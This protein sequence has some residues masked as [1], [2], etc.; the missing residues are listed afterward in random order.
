V[1]PSSS[2][3]FGL[4]LRPR[5]ARP[6]A[7]AALLAALCVG[8]A[9]GADAQQQGLYAVLLRGPQPVRDLLMFPPNPLAAQAGDYGLGEAR[10]SV[11][12]TGETLVLPQAWRARV[13]GELR[14]LEVTGQ[15]PYSLCFADPEGAFTLFFSFPD[16]LEE[17]L[18]CRFVGSFVRRFQVLRGLVKGKLEVPFPGVLEVG[19]P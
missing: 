8:G 10:V 5:R 14:L 18:R 7:V 12:Y 2:R 11:L 13:C 19:G 9:A 17:A 15:E 16:A 4:R 1:S 3:A 6:L